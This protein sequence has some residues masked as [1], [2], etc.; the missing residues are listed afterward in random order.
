MNDLK[1]EWFEDNQHVAA[2]MGFLSY[3]EGG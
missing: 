1:S 2:G 3:Y